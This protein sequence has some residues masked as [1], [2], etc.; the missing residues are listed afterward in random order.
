M[1]RQEKRKNELKLLL[2][3]KD[4]PPLPLRLKDAWM[5]LEVNYVMGTFL[6]DCQAKIALLIVWL[7]TD[8]DADSADFS[9]TQ[10]QNW[11]W[12]FEMG[13]TGDFREIRGGLAHDW[14]LRTD[15]PQYPEL[16]RNIVRQAW[17]EVKVEKALPQQKTGGKKEGK[18]RDSD[19]YQLI[20]ALV[21][22][23]GF[24][25]DKIRLEP[26]GSK[27]IEKE[28]GW[29]QTKVNR[30]MEKLFGNKPMRQ[31]K[32]CFKGGEKLT[33]FMKKLEDGSF[34]VDG[35]VESAQE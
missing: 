14:W 18:K 13:I 29:N 21:K 25:T 22:L 24:G 32:Q 2:K 30:E 15:K 6:G 3:E 28:L 31:Y 8:R 35:I 27:E 9:L 19:R 33:G 12:G 1:K 34:D 23:H 5:F 11:P 20:G 17:A 26:L 4:E 16:L 7:L 10:F